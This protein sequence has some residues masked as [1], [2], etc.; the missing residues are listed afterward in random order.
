[1]LGPGRVLNPYE[2]W[3]A[4]VVIAL[5]GFVGYAAMRIDGSRRGA[6]FFGVMGGLVSSTAVT[7]NASHQSKGN[8][9][10]SLPLASAIAAAQAVMFVRTGVLISVLNAKLLGYAFPP[11]ALGALVAAGAAFF[12]AWRAGKAAN[13]AQLNP[14]S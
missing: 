1:G 10:A 3:W 4:V 12:I 14:G 5:L 6:L 2:L 9:E 13:N 8:E 7:L 11:L